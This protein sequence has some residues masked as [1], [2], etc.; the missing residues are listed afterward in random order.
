MDGSKH[1]EVIAVGDPVKKVDFHVPLMS[2]IYLTTDQ[3]NEI[4]S[5]PNYLSAPQDAQA[6]WDASVSAKIMIL[7]IGFVCSGNP[8]TC[9]T[10]LREA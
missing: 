9:S 3:W 2:L 8:K 1:G 7:V 10:M 5:V 6:K 4:P